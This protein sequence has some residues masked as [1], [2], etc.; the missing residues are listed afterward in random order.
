MRGVHGNFSLLSGGGGR[1][2]EEG[3][4]RRLGL[5]LR[6][7]SNQTG[8][9]I[10]I[11]ETT[12][13]RI[14]RLIRENQVIIFSKKSCCMC[15]TMKRLLNTLR[16]NPTVIE[17]EEDEMSTSSLPA[18]DSRNGVW[19][20]VYIGGRRIG[21]LESLMTLHLSGELILKLREVGVLI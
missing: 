5:E 6:G 2:E 15:H 17:L 7:S 3:R 21:G 1:E 12:E 10:D 19:P 14:E 13:K 20:V 16:V 11:E 8:L 18:Q 4:R 9:T